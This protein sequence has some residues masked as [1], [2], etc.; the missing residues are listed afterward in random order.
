[1]MLDIDIAREHPSAEFDGTRLRRAV[2]AVLADAGITGGEVS[3]AVVDDARMHELNRRYLDH[4]YPTDVLSFVL[5]RDGEH[6]DGQIVVSFD[7]ASREAARYGWNADDEVL[8]YAIHGALHL[9]G[10]DDL[11]PGAKRAMRDAERKYLALFGL[12]PRYD[13]GH[14]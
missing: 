14:L 3:I 13:E 8:L 9:V 5:A 1:M 11:N 4:D 6:L 10:Y 2:K 12:V 7:C